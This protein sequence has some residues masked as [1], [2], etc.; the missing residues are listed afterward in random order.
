M[1]IIDGLDIT[2]PIRP[3]VL[4]LTPNPDSIQETSIQTN[5]YNVD[6]GRAS[7]LQMVMTTKSGT[8]SF[9]GNVSDYFTNQQDTKIL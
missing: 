6:Y 4:N 2:S 9:H 3:G 7:S 1:Y 8:D 5:L